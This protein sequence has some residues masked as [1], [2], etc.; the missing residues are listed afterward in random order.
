MTHSLDQF[1]IGRQMLAA[2]E[3][4]EEATDEHRMAPHAICLAHTA[5][6]REA[7]KR[8]GVDQA[9]ARLS[10]AWAKARDAIAAAKAAGIKS[11]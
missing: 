5:A 7:M 9:E 10:W 11:E 3:A 4:L 2:L 6:E 8:Q 1:K